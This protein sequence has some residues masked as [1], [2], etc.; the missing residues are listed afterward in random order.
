MPGLVAE[1][2]PPDIW[3]N[4]GATTI[5][6][7]PSLLIFGALALYLAGVIRFDRTQPAPWPVRRT[8]AFVS[9]TVVTFV[10]IELFVGVYDDVL[11]Y[12]HMI[13][14]LMLLMIAAPLYAMGAPLDLLD[15]ATTGRTHQ[16]ISK[17][18][19]S[20]VAEIV[21]HPVTAVVLYA[22]L[23]PAA[24]LTGLYNLSLTHDLVHDNEHLAFLAVGYLFWRHAIAIEPA[25][26]PLHPG[27]RLALLAVAIPVDTFTGLAL[28]SASK[29]MFSFY[30]SFRRSWGPS[31]VSDLHIGGSIMWI[32][33]DGVMGLAMMPV[34]V[35]WVRFE[36]QRA[37]E[38]DARLDA[39]LEAER[40]AAGDSQ[41]NRDSS[42]ARSGPGVA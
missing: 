40:D 9:A 10:A 29:E 41:T 21:G 13:Q 14:H 23:I 1:A 24:H 15:R 17:V 8:V 25:R 37:R 16:T 18:L 6:V 2:V 12:D 34:L 42:S 35:R 5:A 19:A 32:G 31:K 22:V 28:V 7:T 20:R 36:E 26:H 30:D 3:H 39:E 38:I 27:V 4:V 33:G 11:F